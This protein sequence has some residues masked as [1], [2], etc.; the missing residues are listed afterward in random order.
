MNPR[1]CSRSPRPVAAVLAV[2]LSIVAAACG[3]NGSQAAVP[4]ESKP[5]PVRVETAAAE[6]KPIVI[7]IDVDRALFAVRACFAV[8]LSSAT[9]GSRSSG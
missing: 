8:A 2:A 3:D 1:P 4:A 7:L 6:Q 5:A 9:S